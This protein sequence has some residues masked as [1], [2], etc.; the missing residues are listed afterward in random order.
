MGESTHKLSQQANVELRGQRDQIVNVVNMVREIG[1]DIIRADKLAS[2]INYRRLL[3]IVILYTLILLLF[4]CIVL[5]ILYKL[6]HYH[7]L[8]IPLMKWL[9]FGSHPH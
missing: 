7:I 1:F 3:H 4:T 6:K 2:D 5:V 8:R 9:G